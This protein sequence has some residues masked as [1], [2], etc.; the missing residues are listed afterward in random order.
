MSSFH[1]KVKEFTEESKGKMPDTQRKMSKEQV[2]FLIK[3][4]LSELVELV[5]TVTDSPEKALEFVTSCIG[6]DMHKNKTE[7]DNDIKIMADQADAGADIIVYIHNAFVKVG[8]NLS[9]VL[10]KV[11]EANMNKRDPVTGKFIIRESDGKVIKP[12][13]W[14]PADIEAEIVRQ[15]NLECYGI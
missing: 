15:I 10:D 1:S 13:G 12:E 3:M 5:E 11:H 8:V 7:Y 6:V 4:C 9:D 14:K 2:E